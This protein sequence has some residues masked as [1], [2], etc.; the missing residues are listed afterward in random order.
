[1]TIEYRWD[2]LGEVPVV[3]SE[4]KELGTFGGVRN[5]YLKVKAPHAFDYWIPMDTVAEAHSEGLRLKID[6]AALEKRKN[7]DAAESMTETEYEEAT[8]DL[9]HSIPVERRYEEQ[10][11]YLIRP[12]Q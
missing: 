6:E 5:E 1:M 12:H 10:A 7:S 9:P 8:D 3:D 2:A 11:E 4:G